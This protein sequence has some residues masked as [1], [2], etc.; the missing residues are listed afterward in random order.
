MK[1]VAVVAAAG[2]GTRFGAAVPKQ[3]LPVAG[4]TLLDRAV[5]GLVASPRVEG[6]VVVVPPGT[7]EG[8]RA[9]LR[10]ME[11]VLAVVDGG[12]RREES[13][14][15]GLAAVPD[16]AEMVL[17][18]DG[19]RPFVSAALVE[20]CL[21]AAARH[22]A[23]VPVVPVRDTIKEWDAE[24]RTLVTRDR[25]VLLRAQTPQAFRA[26]LLREAYAQAAAQGRTGTD[27]AA[28]VEALGHPVAAVPGE[29]ENIKITV[30]ADLRMAHGLAVEEADFRIGLGGDA[31]RLVPGRE[32]WLGGVRVP[33]PR[34]LLGHSDGDVL[35]HAVADALYGAL[36]ERDIGWHFPP[37]REETRGLESRAIVAHARARMVER[38]F[39]LV[40]LDAVVVCEEPRIA[41]LVPAIRSSM[42]ELLGIPPDRVNVKGKTTEGMGFEGRGEGISAWAVALLRGAGPRTA[43]GG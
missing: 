7:G 22:G 1:T 40:G 2:A 35:L 16:E 20:R 15:R 23:A 31:H 3:F 18:H 34:G 26:G 27:C 14:R 29:E 19:A 28:L 36:G 17:V 5:A 21:D 8:P 4:R 41:P 11:R 12:D 24:R 37:D 6:V 43:Q 30:P 38:G 33:H 13:V 39:G 9:A 25:A 10:A 32:L 42:A